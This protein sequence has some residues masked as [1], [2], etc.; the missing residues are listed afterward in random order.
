[1]PRTRSGNPSPRNCSGNS[2][3]A[4]DRRIALAFFS[5]WSRLDG[6]KRIGFVRKIVGCLSF[7]INN[8][9]IGSVFDQE[10]ED[11]VCFVTPP[12]P[13]HEEIEDGEVK[14]G[15][16]VLVLGVD[17]LDRDKAAILESARNL[18]MLFSS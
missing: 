13:S 8:A 2:S 5:A 18:T 7:G 3:R 17:G 1:M 14:G 6:G 12:S 15:L 10:P 11:W 4:F 16:S 9:H